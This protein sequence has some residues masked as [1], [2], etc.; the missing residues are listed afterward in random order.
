M[1][2]D[3]PPPSSVPSSLRAFSGARHSSDTELLPAATPSSRT[4]VA[5]VTTIDGDELVDADGLC[6]ADSDAPPDGPLAEALRDGLGDE[7][8]AG[9]DDGLAVAEPDIRADGLSV[10]LVES[11]TTPA[12]DDGAADPTRSCRASERA[13]GDGLV[14]DGEPGWQTGGSSDPLPADAPAPDDWAA[15][16]AVADEPGPISPSDAAGISNAMAVA[17]ATKTNHDLRDTRRKRR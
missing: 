16:H 1:P 3:V 5:H 4:A 8:G 9:I 2:S 11:S 10:G 7:L 17:S 12:L 13:E 6:D 15:A 14:N